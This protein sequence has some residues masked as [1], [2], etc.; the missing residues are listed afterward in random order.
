MT[1]LKIKEFGVRRFAGIATMMSFANDSTADIWREFM[2]K[3]GS[4]TNIIGTELYSIEIYAA[5]FFDDFEPEREF[6]KWAAV[7]IGDIGKLPDGIKSLTVP[8]GLY[9][10]FTYKGKPSEAMPFYRSIYTEWLPVSEYSLDTRPHFA[11]M[12]DN[13]KGE[14]DD[15]EEEIL[16]PVTVS[17]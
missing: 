13:Y 10:S 1:D 3:R 12:G 4:I 15:S 5:G 9:A 11:V 17:S 14:S 6:E 16:I 8:P 2:P 7:E